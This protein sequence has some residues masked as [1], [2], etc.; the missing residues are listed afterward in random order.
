[1][2]DIALYKTYAD[3]PEATGAYKI[4][5]PLRDA[6][7]IMNPFFVILMGF[8]LV[9]TVGSYYTYIALTGRAKLFNCLLAS[10]FATFI[11]S[12]FFSLGR[13]VSPYVVLTFIAI[14]IINL[15]LTIW[16]K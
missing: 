16:Y 9:A 14:T 11:I 4:L 15:A 13:L 7:P 1:M 5:Y 10:S 3:Y 2:A 8:M 12:I 6:V